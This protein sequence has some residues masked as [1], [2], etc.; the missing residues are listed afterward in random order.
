MCV[1]AAGITQDDFLLNMEEDQFDKVIQVNLK[2]RSRDM[3]GGLWHEVK[4]EGH[5]AVFGLASGFHGVTKLLF[6]R[7]HQHTLQG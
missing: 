4:L 2:V 3:L 5:P 6:N 1:N 7:V